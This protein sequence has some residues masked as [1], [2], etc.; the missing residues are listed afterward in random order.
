MVE[1]VADLHGAGSVKRGEKTHNVEF[2]KGGKTK[3]FGEQA[4]EP[5]TS[6]RTADPSAADSAPGAKFAQGGK[7]KMFGFAGSEPARSGITS[8]R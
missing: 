8:A 2:A 7:G 1:K 5:Q 4:A 6:G 3:M